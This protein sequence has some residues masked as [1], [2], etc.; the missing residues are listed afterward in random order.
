MKFVFLTLLLSP[1]FSFGSIEE[2]PF[3]PRHQRA[4]VIAVQKNCGPIFNLKYISHS[5][6]DQ[7]IDQGI[8]DKHFVTKLE[9]VVRIDQGVFDSY[10]VVVHSTYFS[11]YDH[12][13]KDWGLYFID[14][15]SCE[16]Q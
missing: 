16:R 9:L 3:S 7:K 8:V 4:L 1:I 2:I 11:Q 15:I 6:F 14:S 13:Q 12:N 10:Q 5:E